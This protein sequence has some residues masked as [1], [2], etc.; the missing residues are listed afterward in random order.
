G[1]KGAHETG[2]ANENRADRENPTRFDTRQKPAQRQ[3]DQELRQR[4]PQEDRADLELAVVL[5]DL[6]IGRD[7]I[8]GR[9]D[10]EAEAGEDQKDRHDALLRQEPT[11][12]EWLVDD[13]LADDE[14]ESQQGSRKQET[15]DE[16]VVDPVE[17]VA[18]VKAG[19]EQRES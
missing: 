12:E 4:N 2:D 10:D 7:D 11:I 6:E 9:E 13:E 19:V 17:A 1:K 8:G 15:V 14:G 3:H 5:D 18:L 16:T